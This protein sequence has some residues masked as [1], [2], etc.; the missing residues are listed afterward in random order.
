[1]L[2]G[3]E[4]DVS[5]LNVGNPQ[6]AIFVQEIPEDWRMIAAEAEGLKRFPNRS[7]VSIVKPVS[8]HAIEA[9]FYER[10]AGETRSSGTGSTGAAV[11]AILRGHV[12]SPVEVRTPAGSLQLRWDDSVFLTGPAELI[13]EGIYF[14]EDSRKT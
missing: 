7:N 2:G 9:L 4:W 14:L 3:R 10:G 13:C 6:C 8:E 12:K 11:A 5:I 1:M